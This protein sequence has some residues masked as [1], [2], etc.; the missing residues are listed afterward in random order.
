MSVCPSQVIINGKDST[1]PA[2]FWHEGFRP[3]MKLGLWV[4][5]HR[6]S[7]FGRVGSQV[8]VSDL[9]FDP[10]LSCNMGIYHGVVSTE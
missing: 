9:V 3:E 8:S 4:T 7:D 1:D 6:V 10:V 2:G 5:G